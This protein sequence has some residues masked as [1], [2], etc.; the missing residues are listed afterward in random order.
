M[1][2]PDHPLPDSLLR[3]PSYPFGILHRQVHDLVDSSLRDH[4]ILS[5]VADA[6]GQREV[7][8]QDICDALS[9]DRSEMVRLVDRLE[10]EGVLVR[11][12]SAIDRRKYRISI[13]T[14]GRAR[15]RAVDKKLSAATDEVLRALTKDERAT[16]HA[17]SLKAIGVDKPVKRALSSDRKD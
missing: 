15:V 6:G 12:R 1:S 5:V 3:Y 7:S 11:E 17:L 14:A 2:Q 8:Q 10:E 16:L 4:W 9:L 13:T